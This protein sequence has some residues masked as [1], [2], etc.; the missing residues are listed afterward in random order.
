MDLDV[1]KKLKSAEDRPLFRR[2]PPRPGGQK[3]DPGSQ[4]SDLQSL[5]SDFHHPHFLAP[6]AVSA[7]R[8][9]GS[10]GRQDA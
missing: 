4:T 9:D 7:L 6:S 10:I 8:D 5:T 3:P 2:K 1:P